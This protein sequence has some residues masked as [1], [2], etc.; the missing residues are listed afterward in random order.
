[1]VTDRPLPS[2]PPHQPAEQS[3]LSSDTVVEYLRRRGVLDGPVDAVAELGGGVS[4]VVLRVDG[5]RRS[6]VVKQALPRLRVATEWRAKRERTL[7][8]AAALAVFHDITPECVPRV[9]DL[10]EVAMAM[11]I[12]AAPREAVDWKAALLADPDAAAGEV[13]E[14]LG[15]TLALWHRETRG[16]ADVLARFQDDEALE[17]LRVTPFHRELQRVHPSVADALATCIDDLTTARDCLVHGDF[18]PKNV[19]VHDDLCWVLDAEVAKA[20]SPVFDLAFMTAHLMLKWIH[21]GRPRVLRVA[22]D[23]F[24]E[25]YRA[26]AGPEIEIRHEGWQVAA[27]VLAR[28]DGKSPAEYLTT[29]EREQVRR[30]ALRVLGGAEVST[31]QVWDALTEEA[32]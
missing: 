13:P 32:R 18:S 28:V 15:R 6:L 21:A 30:A 9:L 4:S 11:T 2:A 16:R 29:T 5:V 3:L 25:A 7:S 8:E 17:Q 1:M 31:T 19:L 20:G 22:A 26:D 24:T 14:T 10:D 12:E 23:R 27:L